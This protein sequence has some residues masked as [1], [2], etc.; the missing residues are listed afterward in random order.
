MAFRFKLGAWSG[1]LLLLLSPVTR[2]GGE[3]A[4]DL[5]VVADTRVLG[6]FNRYLADLYNHDLWLFAIHAVVLTTIL[7]GTL[8]LLMDA[9]MKRIGI[10]LGHKKTAQREH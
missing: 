2:A 5:V 4:T 9:I 1:A 7:G 6:G 10:D 8:G 3:K